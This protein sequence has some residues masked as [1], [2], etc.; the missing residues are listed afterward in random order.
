MMTMQF[1]IDGAQ[2]SQVEYASPSGILPDFAPDIQ[3]PE[4]SGFP[5]KMDGLLS[6]ML[7]HE[8]DNSAGRREKQADDSDQNHRGDEM[9]SIHHCLHDLFIPP[10]WSLIQQQCQQNRHRERTQQRS[11]ADGQRIG[12]QLHKIRGRKE[13]LEISESHP[14]AAGD[15]L[16]SLV[17]PEG[18]LD[19]VHGVISE[20][21]EIRHRRNQEKI[22]LPV[23]CGAADLFS[24]SLPAVIFQDSLTFRCHGFVPSF[25]D[26]L[27]RYAV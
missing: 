5:H 16:C 8:I 24:G 14:G 21:Q 11:D 17:I 18:D 6:Q 26:G 4:P 15:A 19:P 1:R 2:R 12:Q 25:P 22:Q 13:S 23:A 10:E 7:Q 20:D 3:G 9:W 27:G